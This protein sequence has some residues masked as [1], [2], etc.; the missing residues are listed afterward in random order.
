MSTTVLMLHGTG[1]SASMWSPYAAAWSPLH[2]VIAPDLTGVGVNPPIPRGTPVDLEA[3]LAIAL[4]AIDAA[5]GKVDLVGH[6]YGGWLACRA[7]LA[8]PERVRQVVAHDPILWGVLAASD[9]DEVTV[10]FRALV[11]DTPLG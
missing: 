11:E 5:P 8:R 7:A 3:D 6:G 2:R 10:P 1:A 4:A 9:N